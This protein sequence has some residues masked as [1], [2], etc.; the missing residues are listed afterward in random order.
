MPINPTEY[1]SS[2]LCIESPKPLT[3]APPPAPVP[4][5]SL[6]LRGSRVRLFVGKDVY[7]FFALEVLF[8]AASTLIQ[9]VNISRKGK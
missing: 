9:K 2:V 1:G 6:P 3:P 5:H 8:Q 4:P 7:A